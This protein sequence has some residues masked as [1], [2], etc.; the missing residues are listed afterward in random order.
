MNICTNSADLKQCLQSRVIETPLNIRELLV[1]EGKVSPELLAEIV[2]ENGAGFINFATLGQL[3]ANRAIIDDE[4]YSRLMA[5]SLGL[6]FVQLSSFE[7]SQDLITM[8]PVNIARTHDLVPLMIC[9][10]K[11]VVAMHNPMD[12]EAMATLSF[13]SGRMVEE[14]VA[15][16]MDIQYAITRYYGPGDDESVLEAIQ[17]PDGANS[18]AFNDAELL[19]LSGEKP[20]VRLV[21]HMKPCI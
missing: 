12:Q 4:D 19:R 9:N 18:D 17:L 10:E 21:H 15:S 8:V 14:A 16:R 2:E 13:L 1:S 5:R 11:L 7:V 3:L 6:P 20:T